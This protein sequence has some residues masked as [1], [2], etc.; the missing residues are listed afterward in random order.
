MNVVSYVVTSKH[1]NLTGCPCYLLYFCCLVD[2]LHILID[3]LTDIP[4]SFGRATNSYTCLVYKPIKPQMNTD[5]VSI[6]SND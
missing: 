1:Y 4:K 2:C 5:L 3:G 6:Y